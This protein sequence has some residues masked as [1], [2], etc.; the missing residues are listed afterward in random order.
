MKS[1]KFLLLATAAAALVAFAACS[2][3]EQDVNVVSTVADRSQSY[4]QCYTATGT[5]TNTTITESY[6]SG[7]LAY[8][9][10][11]VRKETPVTSRVNPATIDWKEST[12]ANG[13]KYSI[14]IPKTEVVTT[15][16][17][18]VTGS[19]PSTSSP[20]TSTNSAYDTL[21][22][23]LLTYYTDGVTHYDANGNTS[24]PAVEV[25]TSG[26]SAYLSEVTVAYND[27]S[28]YY[29]WSDTDGYHYASTLASGVENYTKTTT[30][31][32]VDL[33]FT[34]ITD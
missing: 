29:S 3:E 32:A 7:T 15:S 1:T 4:M 2:D 13:T 17:T 26:I 28:V 11:M 27:E 33:T 20:S 14:S 22:K 9:N 18:E 23:Y 16:T 19:D 8:K 6:S 12:T 5:I 25:E 21:Y 31:K 34:K 24:T 30:K 10:T